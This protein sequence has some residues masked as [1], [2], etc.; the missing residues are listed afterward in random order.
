MI[1]V[2][3]NLSFMIACTLLSYDTNPWDIFYILN[4]QKLSR[5]T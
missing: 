4:L 1:Y 5:N 2:A 3:S